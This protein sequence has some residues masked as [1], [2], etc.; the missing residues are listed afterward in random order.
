[1]ELELLFTSS[2]SVDKD[3]LSGFLVVLGSG[4]F[5]LS[6]PLEMLGLVGVLTLEEVVR[7]SYIELDI[8]PVVAMLTG[9]G[10]R[11]CP[12]SLILTEAEVAGVSV[13]LIALGERPGLRV[14]IR[15]PGVDAREMPDAGLAL[16][17]V[18]VGIKSVRRLWADA[19]GW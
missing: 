16:L 2:F 10:L 1:M 8:I 3:L 15:V 5:V 12:D 18:M 11:G 9:L 6:K 4:V 7:F 13:P 19:E 17:N 14:N